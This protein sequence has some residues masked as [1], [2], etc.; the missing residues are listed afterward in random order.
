M[1]KSNRLRRIGATAL[2][3]VSV[4]GVAAAY[5]F[6]NAQGLFNGVHETSPGQCR[7]LA[8]PVGDI[9]ANTKSAYI[10]SGNALYVFDGGKLTKL[11]GT[12]K[13]FD[14]RAMALSRAVT[15]ETYLR[16]V[17]TQDEGRFAIALFRVKPDAVEEVGRVTTDMLTDPAA[18]AAPD[19]ER[20]YVVNRSESKTAFGRFLDNTL[21]LPRAHLM[22]F[23]GMKF[24][25]VAEHL[26]TPS[27]LALSFDNARL[28]IAQDYPRSLVAIARNDFSGAVENPV[29]L[30]LPSGPLHISTAPDDSLIVAARP[31]TG[32]AEVYRVSL[33]NG[34]PKTATLL[35]A[36]K[37][38]EIRAAAELNGTLLIGTDK[39]LVACAK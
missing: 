28:F 19:P 38:E 12:P 6:A 10:A 15:G 11:S 34:A 2:A 4:L 23:D 22:W 16:T 3:M 30:T 8:G 35:Y 5:R 9:T 20:F 27:G 39:S 31:K 33:E 36:K 25:N 18:I 32:A 7:V 26:N 13:S 14:V 17:L 21:L 24:V 37:G 29:A 1:K